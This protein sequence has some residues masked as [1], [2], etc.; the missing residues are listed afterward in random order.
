MAIE[1]GDRFAV[2]SARTFYAVTGKNDR[3][4]I[5]PC[6]AP[7]RRGV[8]LLGTD[9]APERSEER[10]RDGR[11]GCVMWFSSDYRDVRVWVRGEFVAPRQWLIHATVA[12]GSGIDS[13]GRAASRRRI[14]SELWHG[15]ALEN[16]VG[17][18]LGAVAVRVVVDGDRE[19]ADLFTAIQNPERSIAPT[20][21][22]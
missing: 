21:N 13:A 7:D 12:G 10:S 1:Q 15:V 5:P 19:I 4:E 18:R 14:L 8:D 16:R 20:V 17:R 3:V 11:K 22:P 6:I 2:D 9:V